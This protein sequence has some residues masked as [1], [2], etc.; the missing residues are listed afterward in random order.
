MK[1]SNPLR[2][3]REFGQ[4]PWLDFLD[5]GF[6]ASGKLA[7]LV[8]E[9][10]IKGVTSNPTILEKAISGG[11]EYDGQLRA[12]AERGARVSEAYIEIVA[13]DIRSAADVL[14]PLHDATGG[15]EGY[16]SLEVDPVLSY[17]TRG[18]IGRVI[19]LLRAAA[20]PNVFIK[21]AATKEGLPAIEECLS[22]GIPVNVTLIFSVR[23]YEE[24]AEAYL[25]GI[26]RRIASGQE[27]RSSVSVASFFV[28]RVDAMVDALLAGIANERAGSLEAGMALSLKGKAGI[29]NAR[30]AYARFREI[31]SAPGWRRLEK[32]GARLQ[33]PLWGSTSTKNPDYADVMY[34][35]GLIGPDT[36]DTMPPETIDAFRDHGKV[37]DTLTGSEK[38][39]RKVIRQLESLGIRMDD[40][41]R[42]LEREGVEK[43]VDSYERL[44]STIDRRLRVKSA[45]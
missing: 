26:A 8:S 3:L 13:E 42:R 24:V 45:A 7:R 33:R 4:S 9:D 41:C 36:V 14:R 34:V 2:E 29:A 38:E 19:E 27:P 32:A 31:F 15:E 25:R 40:V 18:T 17:D 37:A 43:F 35:E 11:H 1:T 16:V 12:L 30:I 39:S 20:R 21:I 22:L 10:G 44:L 23:R 6:V 28:S 5:R